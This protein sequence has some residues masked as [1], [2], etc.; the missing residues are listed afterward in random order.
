[1][2]LKDSQVDLCGAVGFTRGA[3]MPDLARDQLFSFACKGCGDCCRGREDIVL[4][5]YDLYRIAK[6]LRLPPRIVAS[7]F[8]RSYI[9]KESLLPVLRLAPQKDAGNNC[10]FLYQNR[11]SIH[12]AKPLACALYPLAQ[13]I[14]AEGQIS[15]FL[16]PVNCGGQVFQA[17]V[18]DYLALYGIDAREPE[19]ITWA[20]S[21]MALERR[22]E[23]WQNRFE[24][25]LLRR[26]YQKLTE[27]LY[28][29]YDSEKP[30][31]PQLETNL[32]WFEDQLKSLEQM[33]D[34]RQTIK[35]IDG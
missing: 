23:Q 31:R 33:Q 21:C 6:R 10:P 22:A 9:G 26:L 4:S 1:M 28:Y 34:R 27:A 19:D 8:C 5:G 16:Q 15:Y 35:K 12:D 30:F 24:P 2:K 25:V 11:C 14:S 20:L 29:S 32:N 17:R 3:A 18:K 7:S 13:E